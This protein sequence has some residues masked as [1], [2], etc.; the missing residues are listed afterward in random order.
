MLLLIAE[1]S[2]KDIRGARSVRPN[3][4]FAQK[5]GSLFE[6]GIRR[7]ADRP[8]S[9]QV[10]S[11]LYIIDAKHFE[12]PSSGPPSSSY[13]VCSISAAEA[14]SDRD[15]ARVASIPSY[16]WN[17]AAKCGQRIRTATQEC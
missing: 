11:K 15:R 1:S 2:N 13:L 7:N 4:M 8:T 5:N 17:L 10:T 12:E 16:R 6:C 14:A 9:H 3:N